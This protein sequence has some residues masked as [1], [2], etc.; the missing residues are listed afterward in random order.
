MDIEF[1]KKKK[2][3]EVEL[4]R[5]AVKSVACNYLGTTGLSYGMR[6]LPTGMSVIIKLPNNLKM[7]VRFFRNN[8][9][10]SLAK[11]PFAIQTMIDAYQ[12]SGI[13]YVRVRNTNS[14]LR[15]RPNGKSLKIM[16]DYYH[17]FSRRKPK[18]A[19]EKQKIRTKMLIERMQRFAD[20][21][22]LFSEFFYDL[23]RIRNGVSLRVK[24]NYSK[25]LVFP[26]N[27]N[28]YSTI[29]PQIMNLIH[30]FEEPLSKIRG[31][32]VQV[33]PCSHRD[34]WQNAA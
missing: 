9:M 10:E 6:E 31:M 1:V 12:N 16:G 34:I 3:H 26:V 30:S 5:A 23:K 14:S 25:M 20:D 24:M 7:D 15:W 29:M 19:N 28:N 17:N 13:K 11:L 4:V 27:I 32:N 2:T 22:L 8:Y 21:N 18:V 33:S